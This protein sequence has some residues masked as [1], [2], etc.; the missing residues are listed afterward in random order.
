MERIFSA[1]DE[2]KKVIKGKDDIIEQVMLAIL[3][4]GHVL[5]ED[6]PGVGKTT[7]AMAFSRVL[8]LSYKR[9]Q[10]TPDVMP[11]DVSGFSMYNNKT[12]EFEYREGGVMCNLFLADE[13][14]R[15]SPKTQSALLEVMEEGRVTVDGETHMLP[16]PFIV[17]ATQNPFGSSGT[18]K[19]PQSQLDRFLMCISMGYPDPENEIAILKGNRKNKMDILEE[20][21]NAPILT[22]IQQAVE[23]QYVDE[24]IYS[25]IVE[26]AN[27]TRESAGFSMGIS[28]RGSIALLKVAKAKAFLNR[29]SY[30]VPQDIID[31]MGIVCAHRIELSPQAIANGLSPAD[32]LKEIVDATPMPKINK[33]TT[34]DG[35]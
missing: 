21:L 23:E 30:V 20:K 2:I 14:N 28:P 32:A 11:S 26:I 4:N 15:T 5:L 19:L 33:R 35:N 18:Q 6:I 1:F 13:I 22:K 24:S 8:G 12:D 17:I 3:S 9:M 10:F 25:Y 31:I 16:M 34:G 27:R 7:L 29:R